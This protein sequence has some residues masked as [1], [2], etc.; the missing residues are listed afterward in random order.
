[1]KVFCLP[2]FWITK[3][4]FNE[5]FEKDFRK[6]PQNREKIFWEDEISLILTGR[7]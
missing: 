3:L 7:I 1:M 6:S 4:I 5:K 2:N